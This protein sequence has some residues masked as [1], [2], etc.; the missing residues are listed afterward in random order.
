M[1]LAFACFQLITFLFS[2]YGGEA[3]LNISKRTNFNLYTTLN[4]LLR[5]H[6]AASIYKIHLD[7]PKLLTNNFTINRI[8]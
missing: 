2:G 1:R 6:T 5:L 4:T 7:N 3:R 8:S